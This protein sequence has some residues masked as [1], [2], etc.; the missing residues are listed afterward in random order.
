MVAS[1]LGDLFATQH[2]WVE[3]C[4][5][6]GS[7]LDKLASRERYDLLLFDNDLP[8]L[9]GLELVL[10]ARS[11]PHRRRTPIIMLSGS[12]CEAEAWRAGVDDFLRKPKG[13]DQ[14]LSVIARLLKIELK[15]T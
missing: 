3:R 14:I 13:I 12:D 4:A 5:D 8:G 6:G 2:W 11:M 7:A 9:S 15:P 10:R 1:L